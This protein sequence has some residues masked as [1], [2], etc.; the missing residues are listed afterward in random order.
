[1]LCKLS[2]TEEKHTCFSM[3]VLHSI[4]NINKSLFFIFLYFSNIFTENNYLPGIYVQPFKACRFTIK[5][6]SFKWSLKFVFVGVKSELR[7]TLEKAWHSIEFEKEL[8]GSMR[9]SIF[10]IVNYNC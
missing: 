7:Q 2:F 9:S 10:L 4:S 5:I 3:F 6:L 1:M 8:A